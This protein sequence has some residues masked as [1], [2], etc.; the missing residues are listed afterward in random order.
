MRSRRVFH[1]LAH[2][3]DIG[4]PF[5]NL[6]ALHRELTAAGWIVPGLEYPNYRTLWRALSARERVEA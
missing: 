5:R 6:P 3:V 1:H 2:H 4:V